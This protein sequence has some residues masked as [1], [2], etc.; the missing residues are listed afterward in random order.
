VQDLQVLKGEGPPVHHQNPYNVQL[1]LLSVA[2]AFLSCFTALD[3]ADRLL[4]G[5]KGNLYILL[6]SIV[7]G[8]GM[9]SMHFIGMRA[10]DMGVPVSYDLL[11]LVFSLIIPV[12]ASY[13]L[14]VML[15]TPQI[16]SRI[17]LGL[18]GMLFSSGI[19]IMH[20]SG[21]LAMKLA[22][23]YEQEVFSIILSV[24]FSFVVPI[25]TA[26]YDSKWLK[27]AY[28]M[29]SIKK[30]LLVL[31]LTGAFTGI[32]YSAMAG[33]SFTVV[34]SFLYTG[35]APLLDD[36]LLGILL[37]GSFLFIVMIVLGLLYRDRQR[38]LQA[39]EFNEQRY[40]ALFE[41]SPDMV[42]CIDPALKKIISA[43]PSLRN[44]TGYSRE[45]LRY[46]KD[47]LQSDMDESAIKEAVLHASQGQSSKLELKVIT[48]SGAQII[49]SVTVFPLLHNKERLV[50]IV[51][52]DVTALMQYQHELIQA[53]DAA[54]S[55]VRMKSEF[56][57]TMSHEIRT[58]LNGIIGINQLLAE[59]ISRP[60]HLELLM[61]QSNSSL[62]LLHVMSDILDI[63]RL[64]ADGLV[65]NQQPFQ[66]TVLLQECMDLF[67]VITKD[68]GLSLVLSVE[69]GLPGEFI[70]DIARIRQILVN[71][72]GNAV[73]FTHSGAVTVSVES[74]GIRGTAQTLQFMVR[75]TGI[76]IP[77]D[78]LQLLFQSF[79]QVDASHTRKYPGTGLGL[80]ICKK[81]VEL[82]E[83]EIW[84]EPAE[85]G[86][87][88]FFVRIVLQSLDQPP[89][90]VFTKDKEDSGVPASTEAV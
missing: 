21:I 80:A 24:L 68:K 49:C 56:L 27:N 6:I 15:S 58:P 62:A 46:Y 38:V 78:K 10:L 4:R 48:K 72:I 84:A 43:N 69:E 42:L 88:Q 89:E 11:L 47:I 37:G 64:E 44:A 61:L 63:S 35:R 75:D 26:S 14:F 60:E 82:M 45:E 5:R 33:A 66:L 85:G 32:H 17:Y 87:T 9:W 7:L 73:K 19:L 16:G 30:L 81:L 31:A 59:E 3:L 77:P 8:T 70:G 2:I 51:A 79:S 23:T 34:D 41:H 18:G 13:M 12:A 90:R 57:A 55:A 39:A 29:F 53:R 74:Y 25:V 52:E 1:V 83:G 36:S 28:N 50:Y 20:F 54:E 67:E 22:A 71:I 65:L 86:G 76:G 40:I